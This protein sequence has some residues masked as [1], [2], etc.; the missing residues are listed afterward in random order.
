MKS[1]EVMAGKISEQETYDDK[2]KQKYL[3]ST[4]KVRYIY[5]LSSMV[6]ASKRLEKGY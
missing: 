4:M 5:I 2:L 3:K 6:I 1:Y